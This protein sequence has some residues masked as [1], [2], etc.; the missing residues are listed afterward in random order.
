M[1]ALF[2]EEKPGSFPGLEQASDSSKNKPS[3]GVIVSTF[4]II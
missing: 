4:P 2:K 3:A 1:L